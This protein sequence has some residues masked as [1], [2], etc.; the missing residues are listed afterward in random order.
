MEPFKASFYADSG[1]ELRSC[2]W[3]ACICIQYLI[4]KAKSRGQKELGWEGGG[5]GG[6]GGWRLL[7][8]L[9]DRAIKIEKDYF[10]TNLVKKKKGEFCKS[11]FTFNK[12]YSETFIC[13]TEINAYLIVT[14]LKTIF[15]ST[16]YQSVFR[17]VSHAAEYETRQIQIITDDSLPVFSCILFFFFL[18]LPP[19]SSHTHTHT[20]KPRTHFWQQQQ[21]QK[22]IVWAHVQIEK[23]PA[24]ITGKLIR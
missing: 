4:S 14:Y 12:P 24:T 3:T 9:N 8:T 11:V 2:P 22:N 18:S 7:S 17:R 13:T 6:G 10:E 16:G 1:D 5:R 20:H 15:S 23:L 19:S 21:Q